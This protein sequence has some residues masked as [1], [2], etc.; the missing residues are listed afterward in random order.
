MSEVAGRGFEAVLEGHLSEAVGAGA[1]SGRH[2]RHG[3]ITAGLGGGRLSRHPGRCRPAIGEHATLVPGTVRRDHHRTGP[4]RA[5][6][7]RTG[8]HARRGN[9]AA[10]RPYSTCPKAASA[11]ACRAPIRN[12]SRMAG[13]VVTGFETFMTG[14]LFSVG[15]RKDDCGLFHRWRRPASMRA[16][17][18]FCKRCARRLDTARRQRI[19]CFRS[20]PGNCCMITG[21]SENRARLS[22]LL[23]GAELA[24]AR[25]CAATKRS[26][27]W[28]AAP[29][30]GSI[31]RHCRMRGARSVTSMRMWPCNVA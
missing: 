3:R 31:M 17:R 2:L 5:L 22:G 10:G 27:S 29:C 20:V 30:S 13:L 15:Y 14:E 24:G 23:I 12:G 21:Q 8:R 18:R 7:Q 6:A 28:R 1:A 11:T 4:R 26:A 9:P 16:I 25:V 19:T